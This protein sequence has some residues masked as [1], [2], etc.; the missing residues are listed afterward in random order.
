MVE[1]CRIELTRPRTTVGLDGELKK[2]ETP[3][4]Y[5]I[6]RDALRL[7]VAAPGGSE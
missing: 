1:S 5:R 6:E 7:I 4:D 2:M 3:L